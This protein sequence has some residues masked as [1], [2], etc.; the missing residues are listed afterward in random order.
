MDTKVKIVVAGY[1]GAGNAGD[2]LILKTLLSQLAG[3][4]QV[5][6]ISVAPEHTALLHGIK[7][8]SFQDLGKIYSELLSCHLFILGGGGMLQTHDQFTVDGLHNFDAIEVSMY[9]R[10]LLLAKQL[11]V[12]TMTWAQGVGPLDTSESRQIAKFVFETSNWASVRDAESLD[13]LRTAGVTREIDLGADPIWLLGPNGE[14]KSVRDHQKVRKNLVITLRPWQLYADIWKKRLAGALDQCVDPDE[15]R[16]T[17][18]P[19]VIAPDG[20]SG[21]YSSVERQVVEDVKS[22]LTKNFQHEYVV[23]KTFAELFDAINVADYAI[24][25]RLHAQILHHLQSTPL[26]S[27]Q[28]DDKLKA[29]SEQVGHRASLQLQLDAPL[30]QWEQAIRDLLLLSEQDATQ[31]KKKSACISSAA[32]HHDV[33]SQALESIKLQSKSVSIG[34]R[35]INFDWLTLW[36]MRQPNCQQSVMKTSFDQA[37]Q[38][39]KALE[40]Q[41]ET[42]SLQIANLDEHLQAEKRSKS[43]AIESLKST[44]SWRM[45]RPLR[46][47]RHFIRSPSYALHLAAKTIYWRLPYAMRNRLALLRSNLNQFRFYSTNIKTEISNRDMSWHQFAQ[48][49][50]SKRNEYRGVFIQECIIDWAVPL[51][52]RPQHIATAMGKLDFLVIY[53]T[54]NWPYD[55]VHGVR[56]I[57]H[58]VW[59]T[60]CDEVDSVDTALRSVYSTVRV[61][62][63]RIKKFPTSCR[64]VFEYIDHID[65]E[66]SGDPENIR[67]LEKQKKF[68]LSGGADYIVA[69]ARRLQEDVSK[70]F[71]SSK[72]LL[73]PNG[74]D[75]RH[76]REDSDNKAAVPESYVN[77]HKKYVMCLGYFGALAPWLDYPMI[78][79][80]VKMRPDI[81]FVF[82]GPDYLGGRDRLPVSPNVL[83]TGAID[84]TH[85]PKFAAFF[86][87]CWIPFK[88]GEIAKSTSPLKLFEYFAMEKPVLVGKDMDECTAYSEVLQAGDAKAMSQKFDQAVQLINDANYKSQLRNLADQNDWI[89][90]ASDYAKLFELMPKS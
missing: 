73:V 10:P 83:L 51:Y 27:I 54:A 7:A 78:A 26:I 39:I 57:A 45:T 49:I 25:M 48:E 4:L 46:F 87:V 33:L 66:I 50:L 40:N 56:K 12:P 29:A 36:L 6:A 88:A 52:Q 70:E 80:L 58:N 32:R 1:Y 62:E 69:S 61:D 31:S 67:R 19:F 60:N 30:E 24:C 47:V 85:L 18:L 53:R 74:V 71:E 5:T 64:L 43:A 86:D 3:D 2:E 11:N 28:Y 77:F 81:G 23:A 8:I 37:M 13:M 79:E 17:W 63:E 76:Y 9:V 38:E 20:V 72:M 14:K 75:A 15:F 21:D 68:M 89:S 35:S 90:R 34:L 84:Y 65:P 82:I 42:L 55:N 59:L 44:V 41:N 22:K 16:I